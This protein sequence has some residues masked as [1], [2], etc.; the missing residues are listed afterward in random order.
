[1]NDKPPFPLCTAAGLARDD[2]PRSVLKPDY[3]L[4]A[5]DVERM[6]ESAP[7]VYSVRSAQGIKYDSWFNN[8][9]YT[10]E[11]C[12]R[13]VCIQPLKPADTAESLLREL[14][15][16]WDDSSK[17]MPLR[18]LIHTRARALLEGEK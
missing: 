5:S 2:R 14:V 18:E 8:E 12:A 1:M 17:E 3:F 10:S 9:T 13:L 7:V 11:D 16:A 6:L 4:K 15:A